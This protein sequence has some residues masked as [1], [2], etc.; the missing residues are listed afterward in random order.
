MEMEMVLAFRQTKKTNYISTEIR[1]DEVVR[2][3][4]LGW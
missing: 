4:V 2:D 3:R 1:M